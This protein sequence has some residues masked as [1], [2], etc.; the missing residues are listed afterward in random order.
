MKKSLI[1]ALAV[2]IIGC[3]TKLQKAQDQFKLHPEEF[4]GLAAAYYPC[5]DTVIVRDSIKSDTLYLQQ[6][7]DTVTTWRMDTV[8]HTITIPGITRFITRTVYRDSLVIR[9][10]NAQEAQLRQIIT[11][12]DKTVAD[13]S[14]EFSGLKS[15]YHWWRRA[16][17][18]TW[19]IL[20]ALIIGWVIAKI[21]GK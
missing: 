11:Q 14:A 12:R 16:G 19:G 1:W 15:S 13:V 18:I 4:A 21:Y 5:R 20:F 10:D 3:T 6:L 2:L 8:F 9:R 7:P 17:F